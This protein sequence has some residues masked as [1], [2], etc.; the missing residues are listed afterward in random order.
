MRTWHRLLACGLALFVLAGTPARAAGDGLEGL[1]AGSPAAGIYGS[2]HLAQLPDKAVL[3]FDYRFEGTL[4]EKPF[5]DNV[6]LD[7]T[8]HDPAD[9]GGTRGYDVAAT[10]FPQSRNLQ[11]GPLSAASVN[12][13]LLIFFQ[14]DA[15]Q[16]S[17]GTGG[18]QHYFRNTIRRVLQTPDPASVKPVTIR[19]DGKDLAASEITFR[20]FADDPN[21]AR[22]REFADKS[23]HFIVSD[24]VPGG[25]YE[26]GAETPAGDGQGVLLRETYRLREVRP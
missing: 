25:V 2:D 14:R 7:F 16:M 11:I 12:P 4:L 9:T 15:T 8:R 17:N 21:R 6:V 26:V 20:P 24:A 23:Y 10:L 3:V 5:D 19:F 22:L 13:I 18:S 1:V